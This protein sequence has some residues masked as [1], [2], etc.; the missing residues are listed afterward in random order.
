VQLLR[1]FD[2]WRTIYIAAVAHLE[3]L[4]TF[5]VAFAAV[6]ARVGSSPASIASSRVRL[7]MPGSAFSASR[8]S[9]ASW[10]SFAVNP[11]SAARAFPIFSLG[12]S[13][14]WR[15]LWEGFATSPRS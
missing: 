13:G 10:I 11:A 12:I 1:N 8:I 9:R 15:R 2:L 6:L 14:P 3:N 7:M 4:K 5:Q